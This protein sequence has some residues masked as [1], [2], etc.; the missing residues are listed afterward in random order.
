M[1]IYIAAIIAFAPLEDVE[2]SGESSIT[3]TIPAMVPAE[4][5]D[6]AAEQ[7]RQ[8]ALARWPTSE[9]WYGHHADIMPI[10]RDF[11]E[12]ALSAYRAGILDLTSEGFDEGRS[13][14]FET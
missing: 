13:Y 6:A 14:T 9:G 8:H 4:N 5:I 11:Y 7:C 1:K 12:K 3:M 2:R 10:T